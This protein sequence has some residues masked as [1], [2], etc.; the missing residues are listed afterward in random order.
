MR[1]KDDGVQRAIVIIKTNLTAIA[2]QVFP[3]VFT[4]C[5][6]FHSFIYSSSILGF[7]RSC[8]QIYF[9]AIFGN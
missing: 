9:R 3:S 2:K 6:I 8:T 4:L 7:G 1:M 5:Y